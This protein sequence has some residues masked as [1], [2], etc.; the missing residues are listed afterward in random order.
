MQKFQHLSIRNKLI[1]SFV[2]FISFVVLLLSF[3]IFFTVRSFLL[4]DIREKQLLNF[5][6]AAQ[7]DFAKTLEK[8]METATVVSLNPALIEWFKGQEQDDALRR[9]SLGTID[10][11]KKDFNY[12]TVSS[13]SAITNRYYTE[14]Y[15][16]LNTVSKE[17][18]NDAW[19]FA[20]LSS[21]KKVSVTYDYNADID[22]TL[23]FVNALIDNPNNPLGVVGLGIKPQEMMEQFVKGRITPN[24]Q[25][26]M[27]DTDNTILFSL[28]EKT[29]LEPLGK[30]TSTILVDTI[31]NVKGSQVFSAI[32]IDQQMYDIATLPVGNTEYRM[33]SISPVKELTAILNPIKVNVFVLGSLFVFL[34]ILFAFML[35]HQI[36]KPIH[37]LKKL[38]HLYAQGDLRSEVNKDIILRQD[39]M[40]RFAFTFSEMKNKIQSIM[41]QVSFSSNLVTNNSQELKNES[42]QLYNSANT[43]VDATSR[44]SATTEETL[45]T[46]QQNNESIDHIDKLFKNSVHSLNTGEEILQDVVQIIEKI[47]NKIKAIE[48]ISKQTNILALNASIEAARAG[49][50]GKGFAVVATEVQGLAEVTRQSVMEIM[51]FSNDSIDVAQ[52]ASAI[53]DKL[54]KDVEN[55]FGMVSSLALASK[56][57]QIAMEQIQKITFEN[58]QLANNNLKASE[59]IS[60]LAEASHKEAIDLNATIHQFQFK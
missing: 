49:I 7:S 31:K 21:K 13:V 18:A 53:F 50:S 41:E 24:T 12:F 34:G 26:W 33:I 47:H 1:L 14:D 48:N 9:L 27:I 32:E 37:Q 6:K 54:V 45:A 11:V 22:Q 57:Q 36:G 8:A 29:I 15:K 16:L 60:E 4:E 39:E 51:D 42:Q 55:T 2:A 3:S 30:H 56:E 38:A 23:I 52:K 59:A 35:S 20:V 25:M 44:L 5:L 58:E 28:D 19:F 43:Q 40:G 17:V 46:I 10:K